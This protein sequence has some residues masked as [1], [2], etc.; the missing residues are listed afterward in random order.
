MGMKLAF[1]NI[2]CSELDLDALLARSVEWGYQG[3]ELKFFESRF[4]L[5]ESPTLKRDP[6]EIRRKFADAGQT[7]VALNT[8]LSFCDP[9]REKLEANKR[10]LSDTI[11]LAAKIGAERVVVCGDV[12][13]GGMTR[14]RAINQTSEILRELAIQAAERSVT[15]VVENIG[16]FASSRAM[17]T[18]NDAVRF[19][20]VSVCWNQ[21]YADMLNERP[22]IS[23]PRLGHALGLVHLTDARLSEAGMI[24][25]YV[26]IGKGSLE[27]ERMIELLKGIAYDGW[28]CVEWPRLWQAALAP[29]ETILPAGAKYLREL[30]DRKPIVLSAYKGDKRAPKFVS[31]GPAPA[32]P[33]QA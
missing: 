25:T 26:E 22:S 24:E 7:L 14:A 5:T 12:L 18:L 30:L 11:E 33:S 27:T 10:K 4:D 19:P 29:A 6:D 31:R 20:S 28:L 15:I 17:W 2:A 1:S 32:K 9:D 13:S 23:I 3:F 21:I 16:D 8:S